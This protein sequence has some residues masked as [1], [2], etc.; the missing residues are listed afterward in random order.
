MAMI[1]G[2][3]TRLVREGDTVRVAI[4]AGANEY[5]GVIADNSFLK[6]VKMGDVVGFDVTDGGKRV[7]AISWTE[8]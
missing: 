7:V 2:T 8:K 5:E 6:N 3:V 1:R 4:K